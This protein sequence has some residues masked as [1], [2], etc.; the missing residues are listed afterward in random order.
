M[1]P[2]IK[3]SIV[4]LVVAF[5]VA[6]VCIRWMFKNSILFKITL[7]WVMSLIFI[8]SNA[9]IAAGRPDLYPYHI[10]L[11][12]GIVVIF[13]VALYAFLVIRKPLKQA[14][15]DL[16]KV[17]KGDLTIKVADKM[18][19][20]K[21]EMGTISRSISEL[22]QNFEEIINGI[23]QSFETISHMGTNIKQA[24]S[25]MAQAAAL[26]AGNLEEI[27][28]SMEEMVEIIQNNSENAEET[29]N[30]TN[31][32][33]QSVKL[34]NDSVL[35]ALS[36]LT[37][38]AERIQVIDDIS[39]Q[40]NILSLNAGV[41]A[42]R[43]GEFGKGFAVVAAEVRNLSNQSK[44][45]AVQIDSVSRESSKFSADAVDS[46]KYIVPNMEK[47]TIL[48]QKIVSATTEQNVG[49]SQINNAIQE[50]N[51][52]TQQNATN[53][54]EMAQSAISLS[55]EAEHLYELVHFFKTH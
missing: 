40:T 4:S 43:A 25:S 6:F 2:V 24:S 31:E 14:I 9:R 36:Y 11:I 45:A 1:D 23:Q 34:G 15:S 21:D 27:S 16:E 50:L 48:V 47:T 52:S 41:E 19:S 20:R 39:Y 17:S 12:V 26:Q 46:L 13:F 3:N 44:E 55:D 7:T 35:K 10:S 29:K 49:V 33:N 8:A 38:I 54:E 5:P 28:T 53:A 51:T 37:E 32:T 22:S 30:I 42:A 18:L